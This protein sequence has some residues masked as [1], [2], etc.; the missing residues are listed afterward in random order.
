M[1]VDFLE[2]NAAGEFDAEHHHSS[3][4]EE[5]NVPAGFEHGVGVVEAHVVGVLILIFKEGEGTLSGHP[6]VEKGH[7]PE[8]NHVSKTS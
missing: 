6:M 1:A 2:G 4:P 8:E 3:N 5:E 7:R